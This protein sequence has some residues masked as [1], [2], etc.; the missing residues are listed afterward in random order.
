[1]TAEN[2]DEVMQEET[3]DPGLSY[4]PDGYVVSPDVNSTSYDQTFTE[5]AGTL[6]NVGDISGVIESSMGYHLS[7]IHIL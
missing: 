5:T 3:M 2:V 4:Y 1:M 6:E 7:L